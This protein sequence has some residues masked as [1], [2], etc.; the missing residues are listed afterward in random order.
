MLFLR[1]QKSVEFNSS[2]VSTAYQ[3]SVDRTTKVSRTFQEDVDRVQRSWKMKINS[4]VSRERQERCWNVLTRHPSKWWRNT[5]ARSDIHWIYDV[6]S[7]D[8]L[9]FFFCFFFFF[10]FFFCFFFFFSS[11]SSSSS[12]PSVSFSS[13]LFSSLLFSFSLVSLNPRYSLSFPL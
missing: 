1:Q 6:C 5:V 3:Y 2:C 13:L 8:N 7:P 11:I 12:S 4:S 9:F 10:F